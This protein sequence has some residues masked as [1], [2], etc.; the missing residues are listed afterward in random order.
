[1]VINK[2]PIFAPDLII[3][4]SNKLGISFQLIPSRSLCYI[5]LFVRVNGYRFSKSLKHLTLAAD[6]WNYR[7][8]LPIKKDTTE[9]IRKEL[10]AISAKL[11][12]ICREADVKGVLLT[13][14]ELKGL[15]LGPS[16]MLFFETLRCLNY[17]SLSEI[18]KTISYERYQFQLK[19]V[20]LLPL[21]NQTIYGLPD[22][23]ISALPE[24]LPE[25]LNQ[26]LELHS[27]N[28]CDTPEQVRFLCSLLIKEHRKGNV[29]L[30][31]PLKNS[32]IRFSLPI[33]EFTIED[34]QKL[35]EAELPPYLARIRDAFVFSSVTGLNYKNILQLTG[36]NIRSVFDGSLWLF[37]WGGQ[38]PLSQ[39]PQDLQHQL[40]KTDHA[41]LLFKLP[42]IQY[43]NASL[44]TIALQCGIHVDVTFKIARK[45]YKRT[46]GL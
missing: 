7:I 43:I 35:S 30:S 3:I 15:F 39:L 19:V 12:R 29:N 21:F 32:L 46:H 28:G 22:I 1:M 36:R 16:P 8:N 40:S 23:A 4:V 37:Y 31:E 9:L 13:A 44:H 14:E 27:I 20:N 6:E 25:Q 10:E 33:R 18:G 5:R 24:N 41:T 45:F 26:F 42:S 34:V 2:I 11:F 38:Y 17:K